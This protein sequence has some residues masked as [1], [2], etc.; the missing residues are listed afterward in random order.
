MFTFTPESHDSR[1]REPGTLRIE[2]R[3]STTDRFN[4][5]AKQNNI[6]TCIAVDRQRLGKRIPATHMHAIIEIPFLG[7][8]LL[9]TF[10]L[11]LVTTAGSPL[12]R[13]ER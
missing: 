2:D 6:V 3:I 4:M 9:N 10:P 7:N 12:L 1:E 13:K 8:G 11:K 5:V